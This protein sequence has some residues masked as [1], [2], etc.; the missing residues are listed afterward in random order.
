M[1]KV[2]PKYK[3]PFLIIPAEFFKTD[4]PS[5]NSSHFQ[6]PSFEAEIIMGVAG[7]NLHTGELMVRDKEGFFVPFTGSEGRNDKKEIFL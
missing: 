1:K 6:S 3:D 7:K 5:P 4:S 2:I